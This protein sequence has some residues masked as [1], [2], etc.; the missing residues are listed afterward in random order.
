M[1]TLF[2]MGVIGFDSNLQRNILIPD[3]MSR[4]PSVINNDLEAAE[5]RL[6]N[7]PEVVLMYSI[8]GKEYSALVPADLILTQDVSAGSVVVNNTVLQISISGGVESITIPDISGM[9]VEEARQILEDSGFSVRIETEYN[10]IF[11]ENAV[12]S[13][14]SEGGTELEIGSTVTLVVS[15]GLDPGEQG[16]ET[17]SAVPN[18]IRLSYADAQKAA[19]DAGFLL[20]ISSKE[21]SAQ[22]G[23]DII[24]AQSVP[25]GSEI[26][27]GNTI[28]L[29]VSLG[30]QII[31]VADVQYKSETE[32]KKLLSDQGFKVDVTYVVSETVAGGLVISQSPAAQT[33]VNPGGTVSL[34]VSKG[35]ES[36]A[37]PSVTGMD[38]AVARST[39]S[40]KGLSVS[41]SYEKSS[42]VA[43]GSV[44]RQSVAANTSVNRGTQITLTVSSKQVLI[45]ILN[46]VG[47]S[48]SEAKSVLSDQGFSVSISE[49]Y[50][51]TMAKGNV[52]SQ[53]PAAGTSQTKGTTIVLTVSKGSEQPNVLSVVGKTQSVAESTLKSLG[54]V[55]SINEVFSDTVPKGSV[56][57]QSPSAG[58]TANKG[59]TITLSVSKGKEKVVIP[60]ITGQSKSSAASKLQSAGLQVNYL[61]A[62]DDKIV[63]DSVVS[64]SPTAG[65]SVD[66]GSTVTVMVSLGKAPNP[67][68]NLYLNQ[69][70]LNLTEGGTAQIVATIDPENADD[71]TVKW[72]S[73][74]ENVITISSSGFITAKAVGSATI[75]ATTNTGNISKTCS[76]TVTQ[77]QI[78]SIEVSSLP[79]K[80]QYNAGEILN[81]S[82]LILKVNYS[83]NTT[84]Y[85]TSGFTCNPAAGSVLSSTE[86]KSVAVLYEGKSTQFS[87]TVIYQYTVTY[88]VNNGSGSVP[89]DSNKYQTGNT[90]NVLF[91]PAPTRTG[92]TFAGWSTSSSGSAMYTSA[93]TKTFQM[94]S[95]NITLY[96]VWTENAPAIKI[97]GFKV[98]KNWDEQAAQSSFSPRFTTN[99]DMKS[100][101][102][103]I[104]STTGYQA[105]VVN[106]PVGK[107]GDGMYGHV[108]DRTYFTDSSFKV[109]ITVEDANGNTDTYTETINLGA[110]DIVFN[111]TDINMN[112]NSSTQITASLIN[113]VTNARVSWI[114]SNNDIVSVSGSVESYSLSSTATLTAKSAGTVIITARFGSSSY[115]YINIRSF[116]VTVNP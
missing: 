62:Y 107:Y 14:G 79:A 49:A 25:A 18:F 1:S 100:G 101:V 114:S 87:V 39:L 45:S 36:F 80:T 4:V 22:F 11:S 92:Y 61:E 84:D 23:K 81:T 67:P 111:N 21:Y 99:V 91:T 51:D 28:G 63:K 83:N 33:A 96:A 103:T 44:I 20:T 60:D 113:G 35:S 31:K 66:K 17:M 26:M 78:S 72:T 110:P 58:T 50:S 94:G 76:I 53:S 115:G 54:F 27:S 29:V 82:G 48:E 52:I 70:S 64:Q 41:I 34:V 89:S 93:G 75:T 19:R 102:M 37:M 98:N 65:S 30:T 112:V 77:K 104:A 9:Y 95:A 2:A 106:L 55:V 116:T 3:G 7:P 12:I 8:T 24:M 97:T 10:S 32:A 15:Q 56:V 88:N 73:S 59:A 71:K 16:E 68:K 6:F 42:T 57:S 40:A 86:L 69:T 109:T 13:Q 90:V 47:K 108:F 5:Q 43:E 46:V 105:A 85:I 38:E 74:N